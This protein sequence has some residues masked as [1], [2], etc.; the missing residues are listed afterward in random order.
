MLMTRPYAVTNFG[1]RVATPFIALPA[2]PGWQSAHALPAGPF[3]AQSPSAP[4]ARSTPGL[5]VGSRLSPKP[6]G[7]FRVNGLRSGSFSEGTGPL[8]VCKYA[9][10]CTISSGLRTP[11]VPHGGIEVFGKTARGS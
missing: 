6:T 7:F 1:Y 10:R 4:S 11:V 3:W 9:T 8:R 2:P 5:L